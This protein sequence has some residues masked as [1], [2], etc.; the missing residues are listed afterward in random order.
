[1]KQGKRIEEVLIK[2]GLLMNKSKTQFLA[3]MSYQRRKPSCGNKEARDRFNTPMVAR[4]GG[5]N[6]EE[7]KTLKTLGVTFDSELKFKQYWEQTVRNAS[8]KL[9][10]LNKIR[11][12]IQFISR[13][14]L[15]QGVVVSKIIYCIE[16]T[17]SCP[18]N[19][20]KGPKKILNRLTRSI[21]GL[22]AWEETRR[23]YQALGWLS[24]Y[25][26]I[27]Y[28]TYVLA[29]KILERGDP[30]RVISRFAESDQEGTW[31]VM[32]EKRPARTETG[33]RT[34]SRR[35][36][37][38]WEE[39]TEDEKSANINSSSEKEKI[40]ERIKELDADWILWGL[41][42]PSHPTSQIESQ[43]ENRKEGDDDVNS[44]EQQD[45]GQRDERTAEEVISTTQE[46]V[47][48]HEV[49]EPTSYLNNTIVWTSRDEITL[50]LI[51]MIE[52]DADTKE[53]EKG[54]GQEYEKKIVKLNSEDPKESKPRST[55]IK[56]LLQKAKDNQMINQTV[57]IQSNLKCNQL[58]N[59]INIKFLAA[60]SIVKHSQSNIQTNNQLVEQ[61]MLK[62]SSKF[63]ILTPAKPSLTESLIVPDRRMTP[64]TPLLVLTTS[65]CVRPATHM[66]RYRVAHRF[67]FNESNMYEDLECK[68]SVVNDD[69]RSVKK[70]S[71]YETWNNVQMHGLVLEAILLLIMDR[72]ALECLD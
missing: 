11:S 61:L 33:K 40:K 54:K 14:K 39:L 3:C 51:N 30:I 13:K 7:Q 23:S 59:Q 31:T 36:M 10:A 72:I 5:E 60:Q 25:E 67:F 56:Q 21:T 43:E 69:E 57:N 46:E 16:A 32:K 6:V 28:R 70:Y 22:W 42:K 20:L 18:K 55:K 2:I 45:L 34:F 29:K 37:R 49:I 12:N 17:S 26:L 50:A 35:V 63:E 66:G 58:N 52:E 15:G 8:Q 1:M 27:I 24:L 65:C 38:L 4:V 71:K 53:R 68:W 48:I 47:N 9:F 44:H 62:T 64:G 41:R 19:V